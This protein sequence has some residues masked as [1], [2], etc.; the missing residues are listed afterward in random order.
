MLKSQIEIG[1]RYFAKVSGRR[2]IVRII[3]ATHS[4]G[5]KSASGFQ[6]NARNGWLAINEETGREITIKSAAKLSPTT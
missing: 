4:D 5:W 3:E 1:G 6:R 2:V